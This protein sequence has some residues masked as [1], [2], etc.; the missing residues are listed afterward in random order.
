MKRSDQQQLWMEAQRRCRL[1]DDALRM[2]K[3]LGLSPRSLIKNIPSPRQQWK[4]PVE[5]W[6]R[7]IYEKRFGA[8]LR[9]KAMGADTAPLQAEREP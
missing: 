3:E 1:S 4:A 5:D 9:H 7:A 6:V 8:G 2:A